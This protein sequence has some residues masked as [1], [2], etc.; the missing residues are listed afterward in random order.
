MKTLKFFVAAVAAFMTMACAQ[1]EIDVLTMGSTEINVSYQGAKQ[2][3]SFST[4]AAWTIE[5]DEDWVSFD[6]EEGTAGDAEVVMTIAANTN[7]EARTAVVTITA[8][9]K[10]TEYVIKQGYASEFAADMKVNLDFKAQAF[11]HGLLLMILQ[12][13][14]LKRRH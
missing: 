10:F 14:H 8:G 11:N 4:N 7:Y 1:E 9:G 5:A 12:R 6:A 3:L 13:Q 2:T